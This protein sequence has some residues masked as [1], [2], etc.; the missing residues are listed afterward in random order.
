MALSSLWPIFCT[1]LWGIPGCPLLTQHTASIQQ[2]LGS[3]T[4]TWQEEV[5]LLGIISSLSPGRACS[6][7]LQKSFNTSASLSLTLLGLTGPSVVC[8]RGMSAPMTLLT[9]GQLQPSTYCLHKQP[10]LNSAAAQPSPTCPD[11]SPICSF[12]KHFQSGGTGHTFFF[13]FSHLPGKGG[14]RGKR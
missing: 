11:T 4:P 10:V 7:G 6:Q 8:R 9:G 14:V 12:T 3:G 13:F 1:F 2:I 5:V